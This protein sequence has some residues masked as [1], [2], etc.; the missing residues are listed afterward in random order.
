MSTARIYRGLD[1]LDMA[2]YPEAYYDD[3]FYVDLHDFQCEP[4]FHSLRIV[5]SGKAYEV[6][7]VDINRSNNTV[8]IHTNLMPHC[9]LREE[10]LLKDM[11]MG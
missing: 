6:R 11:L 7:S 10:L 1:L 9:E 8:F 3:C 4:S 2:A 5:C